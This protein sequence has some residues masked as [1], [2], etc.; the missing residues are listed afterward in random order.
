MTTKTDPISGVATVVKTSWLPMIVIAL[1]QIQIGF[2]VSALP[3][4][5]GGIVED[6]STTPS[7]VSTPQMVYLPFIITVVQKYVKKTGI[8]TIIALMLPYTIVITIAWVLL[9]VLWIVLGNLL[10]PG[11]PVGI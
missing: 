5:I 6:F 1:A 7:S 8:G 2:N 10:G 11:Y 3:V 9:F 4:S